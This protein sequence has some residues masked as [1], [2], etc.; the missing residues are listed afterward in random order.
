MPLSRNEWSIY[1]KQK[2]PIFK[3][4][5]SVMWQGTMN[6]HNEDVFVQYQW[7]TIS[8][9]TKMLDGA[10]EPMIFQYPVLNRKFM[11]CRSRLAQL[12]GSKGLW[13]ALAISSKLTN[14]PTTEEHNFI[15]NSGSYQKIVPGIPI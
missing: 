1:F 5:A 8:D 15:K 10:M 2:F 14:T 7:E 11:Q 6:G 9:S 13:F 4:I 3:I 12:S